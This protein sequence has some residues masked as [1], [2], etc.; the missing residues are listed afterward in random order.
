MGPINEDSYELQFMDWL[1][2]SGWQLAR[3]PEIAHDGSM[4][5]RSSH[6]D[7]VLAERLE[8]AL[9]RINPGL[10][11]D[12]VRKVRQALES[13]GET[14][15]LKANKQIHQWMT[16]GYPA[17]VRDSSGEEDTR[18][19]WL[20]D[21]EEES[22]NDWLAV[23]QFSVQTDADSGTRRPD[24]VLFLNGIPVGVVELKNPSSED[25]DIR[26]AFE[27]LQTYKAQI[28][29]LFY[30]NAV[31]VIADGAD[32]RMGSLTAN[33]ERFSKW[34]STDGFNLDPNGTF[35]HAQTLIEGL[36]NKRSV[37][38]LIRFFSVFVEG[39]P[40]FKMLPAYHQFYAVKKA[41]ARA[42]TASAEGGDGRGGG[43]VR[44][45]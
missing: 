12:S 41:Y 25:A 45:P 18:L 17:T 8:D 13:P 44:H 36:L 20:I 9:A 39:P 10:P 37:L 14:D 29:R 28:S 7:V 32:A 42:I 24:I 33:Y 43:R 27:Q 23:N 38:D 40:S 31:L 5:E 35:G 30:Y 1:A 26:Q 11:K 3:G 19:V 16:E 21:F 2:A 4:P 22:N 15:L 34:R 6:K